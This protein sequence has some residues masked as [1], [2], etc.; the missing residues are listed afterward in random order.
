MNYELI[1]LFHNFHS[2]LIIF[3]ITLSQFLCGIR[4]I[5]AH[6]DPRPFFFFFFF[7][8]YC[9]SYNNQ[10]DLNS[11][12]PH[13]LAITRPISKLNSHHSTNHQIIFLAPNGSFISVKVVEQLKR[14]KRKYEQKQNT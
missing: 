9:F 7:F 8:C 4:A 5:S 6:F 12:I 11:K 2:N 3:C 13:M 14:E 10:L 1:V